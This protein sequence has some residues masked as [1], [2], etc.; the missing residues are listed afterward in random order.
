MMEEEM[1][2]WNIWNGGRRNG[3][4]EWWKDGKAER[5]N[6]GMM[7]RYKIK[8]VSHPSKR[9]HS[10]PKKLDDWDKQKSR[11]LPIFHPSER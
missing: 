9:T 8:G 1:E 6:V 2:C 7:K 11:V 10:L 5:W 3:M 4:M